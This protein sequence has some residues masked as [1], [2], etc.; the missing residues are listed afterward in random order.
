MLGGQSGPFWA[1]SECEGEASDNWVLFV[2]ADKDS[3]WSYNLPGPPGRFDPVSGCP[4]ER[5]TDG[6]PP[7]VPAQ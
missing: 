4:S 5:V 1:G 7:D 2:Y 3:S 6:L